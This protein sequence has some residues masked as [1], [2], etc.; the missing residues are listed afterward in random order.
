M[1]LPSHADCWTCAECSQVRNHC[2]SLW[3]RFAVANAVL[4]FCISAHSRRAQKVAPVGR[5]GRDEGDACW[6]C[7]PSCCRDL[8]CCQ[9]A[10]CRIRRPSLLVAPLLS[11]A[12][13]SPPE[14]A[15]NPAG[16]GPWSGTTSTSAREARGPDQGAHG[17]EHDAVSH[18]RLVHQRKRR[19]L[20]EVSSAIMGFPM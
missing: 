20:R 15:Q 4:I 13:T 16:I 12:Q 7:S 5:R 19:T 3:Q 18:D 8:S 2:P 17:E 10:C 14:P 9:D 11:S 6:A 1:S